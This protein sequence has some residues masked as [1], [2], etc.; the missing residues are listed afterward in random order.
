MV[1]RA[2]RAPLVEWRPG[3]R[4]RLHAGDATGPESLCII[5]QWSEPEKGAPTHT[6]FAVEEVIA[7][8]A[9]VA[10]VWVDGTS[11]SL[12]AG[13]SV[14]L[15]PHSWHGFRNAGT[16]TLHTLAVLAAASPL[17][18]YEH[19]RDVVLEVGGRSETMLDAHRAVK[20]NPP[21]GAEPSASDDVRATSSPTSSDRP[22][23]PDR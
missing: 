7:V 15:P 17:V 22:A 14:V 21:S 16:A 23:R 9:G 18:C 20:V 13:D 12:G 2:D 10:E 5:E 6:H 19:E 3:V 11:V 8:L 1:V 4:T